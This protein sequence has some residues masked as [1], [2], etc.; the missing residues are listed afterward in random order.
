MTDRRITED[1]LLEAVENGSDDLGQTLPTTPAAQDQI[2][3]Q[4]TE[5]GPIPL[6]ILSRYFGLEGDARQ[7][8]PQI[9]EA[10]GLSQLEVTLELAEALRQL[11][12]ADQESP[13]LV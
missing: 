12:T 8:T 10:L 5:L 13:L 7:D 2:E 6:A 11:R 1:E 9:A 4:L 3:Q